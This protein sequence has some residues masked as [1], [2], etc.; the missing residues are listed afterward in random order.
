MTPIER[1]AMRGLLTT[2]DRRVLLLRFRFPD[3]SRV[4]WITPGGGLDAGE[5]AMSGLRR[6]LLEET[7]RDDFDVGPEI[8]QQTAR[9]S[10]GD[11][12]VVQHNRY[13]WIQTSHF[14]PHF[15]ANPDLNEREMF[16]AYRWWSVDS[17]AQSA[18]RFA[19]TRLA[20]RLSEL[21]ERGAPER[22]IDVSV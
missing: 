22:P 19:P 8:W 18:E 17:I 12:A 14:E 7:G 3:P 16:E 4:L 15:A 2:P 13:F 10:F 11:Q 20:E 21:F 6:E 9:F 5:E 1:F